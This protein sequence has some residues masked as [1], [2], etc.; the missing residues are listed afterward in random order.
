[1]RRSTSIMSDGSGAVPMER[2]GEGEGGK[3]KRVGI[4]SVHRLG[5][6]TGPTAVPT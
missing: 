4:L 5:C 2:L 6:L 3:T 1:M